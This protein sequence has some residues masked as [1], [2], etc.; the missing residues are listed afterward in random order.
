[1]S[2]II[3]KEKLNLVI[4]STMKEAGLQMDEN[5]ICEECGGTMVEGICEGCSEMNEDK[6]TKPDFLDLDKDGDKEESMK[7]AAK[8]KEEMEESDYMEEEEMVSEEEEME[9]TD[10]IEESI[11]EL[12]ESLS[13][14]TTK[15]ILKEE[16]DFFNRI[17]NYGK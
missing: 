1:M 16:L 14:T 6:E 15:E 10:E 2:K 9:E 5:Q 13:N 8:D 3:T 4:E 17:I 11:S 12:T 7:K